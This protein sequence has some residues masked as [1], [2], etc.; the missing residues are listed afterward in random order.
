M[1]ISSP[2]GTVQFSF[3]DHLSDSEDLLLIG[4]ASI[5]MRR[6]PSK[7]NVFF[8]KTTQPFL[9]KFGTSRM[10]RKDEIVTRMTPIQKGDNSG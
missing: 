10:V 7:I 8:S 9:A 5:V 6:P 2:L 3:L 1:V 4:L